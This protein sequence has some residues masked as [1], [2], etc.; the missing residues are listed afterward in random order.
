MKVSFDWLRDYVQVKG[1]STDL[2]ERLTN[3]GLH[4][5]KIESVSDDSVFEIEVT[6]NRPDWLSHIGVARELHAITGKPF[7]IP[8]LTKRKTSRTMRSF[9]ILV[10]DLKFCPYYSAV[11]LEGVELAKTPDWMKK[12]IEACGIRS[13]NL[14][15]DITNYVM[16][17]CGQPLHAFDADRLHGDSI[18]ARRARKGETLVAIDD[19]SYKLTTDD[20]V[21]ADE[22][23][24]IAIGGVMGGKRSEVSENTRNVLIESAFFE[25]LPIRVTSRRLGLTSESSYRFERGVDPRG[26]DWARD[27]AV[28]LILKYAKVKLTSSVFRSGRLPMREPKI[29]LQWSEVKRILGVQVPGSSAFLARLGLRVQTGKGT[30]T[31]GIPTFRP[32][33]SRSAD[34]IEEIARLYGYGRIPETFPSVIPLE[35]KRDDLLDLTDRIRDLGV[36]LGLN[37]A[38]SFSLVNPAPLERL[39]IM[40]ERWVRLDNPRNREL[41]LMRPSLL[42]GLLEA[43]RRNFYAG[44]NEIAL[45]EVGNR[46]LN[47]ENRFEEPMVA[48][49]LAGERRAH[50]LDSARSVGFYDLK[51][52]IEE[53]FHR[54]GLRE[55]NLLVSENPIYRSG[56]CTILQVRNKVIGCF[57]ALSERVRSLY[58]VDRPVFYGEFSLAQIEPF[59]KRDVSFFE[60]P[61]YPA[62]PRN[63]T[64]I[65][66]EKLEA[67]MIMNRIREMAGALVAQ[68]D[69]MDLFKGGSV[70]K[71]KKSLSFRISYQAKDRTLQNE[72]VNRLHFSIID[73]LKDSFGAQ[74]P[75]GKDGS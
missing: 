29:K 53:L 2:A 11:L 66:E 56:E 51:G 68:I 50:W 22:H 9:K 58:D 71:G 47:Q 31:V 34:L 15:V 73:S 7:S 49:V 54:L 24:P 3:A 41:N 43:V 44:E 16:L 55:L 12:R 5:E 61:K 1:S 48:I 74:L 62:S 38:I 25:P 59:W 69:V 10:P 13:I 65:M 30:I 64:L 42:P 67:Q 45:F 33:L 27:R 52:L 4:V 40:K 37:E 6:S 14:I 20:V 57:G 72:E 35:Q 75:K 70:P 26:V 63:L 60:I 21:S 32:D 17:E 18:A 28:D 46:Y 23:G 36:G 19:S 8:R 39:G